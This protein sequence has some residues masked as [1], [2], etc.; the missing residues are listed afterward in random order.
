LG[1]SN[2]P[3]TPDSSAQYRTERQLFRAISGDRT[4]AAGPTC[5]TSKPRSSRFD[6]P[7]VASPSD[8]QFGPSFWTE[9]VAAGDDDSDDVG[10]L[11]TPISLELDV[12][13]ARNSLFDDQDHASSIG[14]AAVPPRDVESGFCADYCT[15]EVAAIVRDDWLEETIHN[16]A[17][18]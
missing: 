14:E 16:D 5:R 1:R 17:L 6:F 13:A 18:L 12:T 11:D 8:V 2:L 9:M 10:A 3:P 4:S 7:A 15:P